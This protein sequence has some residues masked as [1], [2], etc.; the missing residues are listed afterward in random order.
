M[1]LDRILHPLLCWQRIVTTHGNFHPDNVVTGCPEN[2]FHG[3]QVLD[4]DFSGVTH[5]VEDLGMMTG[6]IG[7][8]NTISGNTFKRAFIKGYLEQLSERVDDE[9]VEMLLV[10]SEL[11]QLGTWLPVGMVVPWHI[12][13][14]TDQELLDRVLLCQ[15][16]AAE[17]RAS[18]DL[19]ERFR[20]KDGLAET[21]NSMR[22][23]E[24][25]KIQSAGHWYRTCPVNHTKVTIENSVKFTVKGVHIKTDMV[26][27]VC[28]ATQALVHVDSDKS[29]DQVFMWR[30]GDLENVG[31]G[32]CVARALYSLTFNTEGFFKLGAPSNQ[33]M[34][35]AAQAASGS[36]ASSANTKSTTALRRHDPRQQV[37]LNIQVPLVCANQIALLEPTV[38]GLTQGVEYEI[39]LTV[40]HGTVSNIFQHAGSR[41]KWPELEGVAMPPLAGELFWGPILPLPAGSSYVLRVSI[42]DRFPGFPFLRARSKTRYSHKKT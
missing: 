29:E 20:R 32:L 27:Q 34:F 37:R 23:L 17:V 15:R 36:A 22:T 13:D 1:L 26:L 7:L 31:T 21:L 9:S 10:D 16:F 11:A 14:F 5:A 42:A 6:H 38:L 40:F 35:A 39:I 3:L 25:P 8:K 18:K 12:H 2:E 19:Q 4:F 33:H 24:I 28:S 41:Y 30:D